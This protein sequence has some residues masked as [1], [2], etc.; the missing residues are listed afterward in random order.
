[1]NDV[2]RYALSRADLT[3]QP[4]AVAVLNELELRTQRSDAEN[5]T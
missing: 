4:T 3:L 1:M 5:I 2:Q